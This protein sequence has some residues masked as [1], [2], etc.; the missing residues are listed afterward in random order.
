MAD[1]TK[2]GSTQVRGQMYVVSCSSNGTFYT[3]RP[4][5]ALTYTTTIA[6]G[7]TYEAAIAGLK[8]KVAEQAAKVAIP[9]T[10]VTNYRPRK[11]IARG[12]HAKNHTLLVTLE[13][14][15]EKCELSHYHDALRPLTEDETTEVE[16][17]GATVRQAEAV[18]AKAKEEFNAYI[19]PFQLGSRFGRP[20][21]GAGNSLHDQVTAAVDAKV[22]AQETAAQVQAHVHLVEVEKP[23]ADQSNGTETSV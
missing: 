6:H 21:T 14:P 1:F 16:R 19:A 13:N 23:E 15:T 18:A 11:G 17:L 8:R 9:F 20:K 7:A 3:H 5:D 4:S 10:Q 2:I 22:K 12:I